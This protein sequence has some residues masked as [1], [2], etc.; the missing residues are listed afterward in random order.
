MLLPEP[1]PGL[2]LPETSLEFGVNIKSHMLTAQVASME[3]KLQKGY[4]TKGDWPWGHKS[5][6]STRPSAR[7]GFTD[8]FIG[9][10]LGK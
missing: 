9:S 10:S 6:T 4:G 5:N 7:P 1:L 8:N 3:S 2:C